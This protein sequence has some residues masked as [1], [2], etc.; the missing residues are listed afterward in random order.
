MV[1]FPDL[2]YYLS[3]IVLTLIKGH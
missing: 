1:F 2:R 3:T